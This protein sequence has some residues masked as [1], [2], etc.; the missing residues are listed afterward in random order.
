MQ[1]PRYYEVREIDPDEIGPPGGRDNDPL[2]EFVRWCLD[3]LKD[4]ARAYWWLLNVTVSW[5]FSIL[6]K[7]TGWLCSVL[8]R[9]AAWSYRT[10]EAASKRTHMAVS[11]LAVAPCL[12]LG[13][14]LAVREIFATPPVSEPPSRGISASFP[15][16]T[17][18]PAPTHVSPP[19]HE[20]TPAP[21]PA[22]TTTPMREPTPT[23]TLA[24]TSEAVPGEQPLMATFAEVPASHNGSDAIQFRLLFA[25]PVVISYKVLQDVA[26]QATN[27]TVRESR[28]VDGR[29]DLWVVTVEPDGA[30]DMEITLTAPPDCEDAAAVCAR[31]GKLLANSPVVRVPY[32]DRGH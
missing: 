17:R 7:G 26:I 25:E 23:L 8:F 2:A 20:P 31:S 16:P 11:L 5:L 22:P 27:G 24:P 12:G 1:K 29:S 30:R 19:T 28:R 32:R 18:G 6:L 9:G 21:T 3:I 14:L 4:A 13:A 10:Y 15:A